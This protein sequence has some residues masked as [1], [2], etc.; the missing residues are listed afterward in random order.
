MKKLVVRIG[1]GL[2]NQMF[3]FA[4]GLKLA[5]ETGRSLVLDITEPMIVP[6]RAYG[7]DDFR[8]PRATAKCGLCLSAVFLLA[9]V[10]QRFGQAWTRVFLGCCGIRWLHCWEDQPGFAASLAKGAANCTNRILYVSGCCALL[11]PIVEQETVREAFSPVIPILSDEFDGDSVSVHVRR[12]DYGDAALG[13]TYYRVAI[14][15]MKAKVPRARWFVFSDDLSWCRTTFADL[16]DCVFVEGDPVRP[17][18]DIVKMSL[19]RHHIVANSTFS[20]WGSYLSSRDGYTLCPS[21]WFGGGPATP[22]LVVPESWEQ[23]AD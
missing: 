1:G 6:G 3:N 17:W 2:G 4:V 8:G 13:A 18:A 12:T 21:R 15:H 7:L 23:V 16:S 14:A 22:G 5:K 10:L 19:C 11:P 20:W 9:R